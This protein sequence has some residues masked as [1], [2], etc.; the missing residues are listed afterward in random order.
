MQNRV[1]T[2]TPSNVANPDWKMPDSAVWNRGIG[3]KQQLDKIAREQ[4]YAAWN[5][6]K[7]AGA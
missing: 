4:A 7:G 5:E 1:A 2:P 3:N 6:I